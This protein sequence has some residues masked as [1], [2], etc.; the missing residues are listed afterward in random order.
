[1][2]PP[3]VD[4][5]ALHRK[6]LSKKREIVA[7]F[8]LEDGS[9]FLRLADNNP[10]LPECFRCCLPSDEN[11][12]RFQY[13]QYFSPKY[14]SND[15]RP[16]VEEFM[17]SHHFDTATIHA[18]ENYRIISGITGLQHVYMKFMD[19]ED[20]S[21]ILMFNDGVLII[22]DNMSMF[23]EFPD[24]RKLWFGYFNSPDPKAI[25]LADNG[26]LSYGNKQFSTEVSDAD[27]VILGDK[28]GIVA[29]K[30][31]G[32][33]TVYDES[34]NGRVLN[35]PIIHQIACFGSSIT[36]LTH[37]GKAMSSDDLFH[38]FT[39]FENEEIVH[40]LSINNA[41]LLASVPGLQFME[42]IIIKEK[43]TVFLTPDG[44]VLPM[45]LSEV[46]DIYNYHDNY[47]ITG[48]EFCFINSTDN[49]R[50]LIYN[51]SQYPL[52]VFET[53]TRELFPRSHLVKSA[54]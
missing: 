36:L 53:F 54:R 37:D 10:Y 16:D 17:I 4:I 51:D 31:D 34:G 7:A 15:H 1:M 18:W 42:E 3:Y 33:V 23:F 8:R 49:S 43:K 30:C 24:V 12:P 47:I 45:G 26:C 21:L 14:R 46:S 38:K 9:L 40:R 50:V 48:R 52:P 27:L 29:L 41:V 39:T 44:R 13:K 22:Q 25:I 20:F 35:V 2:E 6:H 11:D 19:G 32:T 5:E 28:V